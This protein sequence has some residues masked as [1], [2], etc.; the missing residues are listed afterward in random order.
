MS[1]DEELAHRLAFREYLEKTGVMEQLTRI[2][3]DMYEKPERPTEPL[4]YIRDFL[5]VSPGTDIEGLKIENQ[6]LRT[7]NEELEA[8]IDG[9]MNQL[10]SLRSSVTEANKAS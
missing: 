7:R 9:L 3:V 4:E 1:S 8:T 2:L 10:E 6:E 5:G